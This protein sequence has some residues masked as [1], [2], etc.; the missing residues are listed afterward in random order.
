MSMKKIE[1]LIEEIIVNVSAQTDA[2]RNGNSKDG[3]KYAKK[4]IQAF[5]TLLKYG[6]EGR[7]ALIPLMG[8]SRDDVRVMAASFL[9]KYKHDKATKVLQELSKGEG[10]ISF[11]AKESLKR[12]SEGTWQLDP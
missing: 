2:I 3:N 10:F 9:L 11:S 12:W 4:Y 8:Y 7:D 6:N 5:K 1:K